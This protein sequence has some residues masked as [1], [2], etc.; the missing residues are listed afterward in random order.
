[1][2]RSP[3]RSGAE[4][5]RAVPR[6]FADRALRL[7]AAATSQGP[8]LVPD[9]AVEGGVLLR[10]DDQ[11]DR[12]RQAVADGGFRPPLRRGAGGGGRADAALADGQP[13]LGPAVVPALA[14]RGGHGGGDPD[15]GAAGGARAA[16]DRGLCEGGA[17]RRAWRDRGGDR[18]TRDRAHGAAVDSPASQTADAL[19]RPRRRGAPS[20]DR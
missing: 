18:G 8:W 15:L 3:R 2:W 17:E 11:H 5:K 20:P 7:R 10:R 16:P 4:G 9:P 13:R 14:G 1:E 19:G 12:D 6:R